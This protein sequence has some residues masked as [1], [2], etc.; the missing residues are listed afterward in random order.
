MNRTC[1]PR[2]VKG[3][4][5]VVT[6]LRRVPSGMFKAAAACE[7][8]SSGPAANTST[9]LARPQGAGVASSD[10][11]RAVSEA[12]LRV[13]SLVLMTSRCAASDGSARPRRS[14]ASFRRSRF[15]TDRHV[16]KNPSS[17]THASRSPECFTRCD[18]PNGPPEPVK[19]SREWRPWSPESDGRTRPSI[20]TAERSP[21]IQ[22][23]DNARAARIGQDEDVACALGWPQTDSDTPMPG[24]R[25]SGVLPRLKGLPS[26]RP[27]CAT[28]VR[29]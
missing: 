18:N 29:P 23:V 7:I 11:R 28:V 3:T 1:F 19:S 10:A 26:V 15:A 16:P 5:R 9:G 25:L 8:V 27:R 12:R 20:G 14:C 6:C 13:G 22:P 4:L 24:S 2:R 17:P 21:A